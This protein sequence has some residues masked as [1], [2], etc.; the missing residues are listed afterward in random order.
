[1]QL[2]DI[3]LASITQGALIKDP[4]L[5]RC[6]SWF[7]HQHRHTPHDNGLGDF[8]HLLLVWAHPHWFSCQYDLQACHRTTANLQHCRIRHIRSH[9]CP[10][11]TSIGSHILVPTPTWL[12][13]MQIAATITSTALH[14]I[15]WL[16]G[17]TEF[18]TL[19][20][21]SLYFVTQ[22][23]F[24]TSCHWRESTVVEHVF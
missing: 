22:L 4:F 21:Y 6:F 11:H 24:L 9:T 8:V 16:I 7:W 20:N 23:Y 3:H 12:P 15:P 17:I 19:Y 5:P 18:L 1:M 13:M 14:N 10:P 2:Q